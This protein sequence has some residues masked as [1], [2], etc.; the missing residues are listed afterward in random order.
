M[1][2]VAHTFNGEEAMIPVYA[3]DEGTPARDAVLIREGVL[4]DFMNSRETSQRLGLTPTGSARA[5]APTGTITVDQ[6][7]VRYQIPVDTKGRPITLI[8]GCCLTGKTTPVR[9]A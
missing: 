6:M 2:D 1:V 3:D 8:H 9:R 7:Y 5:F 4:T